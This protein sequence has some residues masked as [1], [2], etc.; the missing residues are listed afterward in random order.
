M[1]K[2]PDWEIAFDA[3]LNR[4]MYKPFVWGKW[5]CVLFMCGFIKTMTKKDLKPKHWTWNTEEE[6]MQAILKYGKGKGLTEGIANAVSKVDGIE[7]IDQKF[8]SKGDFGVYKEDNELAC[9]F[10]NYNAL[11]VNDEGIVVKTDVNV[12]KAWR[13]SG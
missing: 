1:K 11:G 2:I 12:I 4:N 9:V 6:A 13:I 8:I 10:D 5:D 3:Y 7:E